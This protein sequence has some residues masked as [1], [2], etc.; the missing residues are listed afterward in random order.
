M[1]EEDKAS[2]NER[3]K[4][5][6]NDLAREGIGG[7]S[8]ER[9]SEKEKKRKRI[10]REGVGDEDI[11]VIEETILKGEGQKNSAKNEEN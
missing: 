4:K 5:W 7:S 10:V 6:K 1:R 9:Q 8:K 2:M 11:M 3:K